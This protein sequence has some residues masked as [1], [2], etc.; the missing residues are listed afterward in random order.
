[1]RLLRP[2]LR[3]IGRLERACPKDGRLQRWPEQRPHGTGQGPDR[4]GQHSGDPG[5]RRFVLCPDEPGG[6]GE[7]RPEV[8]IVGSRRDQP[9]QLIEADGGVLRAQPGGAQRRLDIVD[10]GRNPAIEPAH[11]PA[12]VERLVALGHQIEIDQLS[13]DRPVAKGAAVE[14][15]GHDG[16]AVP[17]PR[18]VGQG[19]DLGGRSGRH[20]AQ[21]KGADRLASGCRLR[22]GRIARHRER[23]GRAAS[24][25][26]PRN[27]R[28]R[29]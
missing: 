29:W 11:D 9:F 8:G 10:I 21:D 22:D 3:P 15:D 24:C 6:L 1:M 13:L 25:D 4:V 16:V 2:K 19:S 17:R 28:R 18:G 12:L 26:R 27:T 23:S 14:E 5:R 7:A 20:L